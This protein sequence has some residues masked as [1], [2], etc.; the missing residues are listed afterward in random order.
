[1][2]TS[3]AV[4]LVIALFAIIVVAAFIVFRRQSKVRIRGP[5]GT[6]LEVDGTNEPQPEPHTPGAQAEGIASRSGGLLVD[7][8]TGQGAVARDVDV[9]DDVIVSSSPPA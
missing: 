6:G 3:T 7:D 5:W 4:V 8:R 1:M 2:D 9:E